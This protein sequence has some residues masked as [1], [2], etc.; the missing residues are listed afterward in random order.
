MG[1]YFSQFFPPTPEFT[2]SSL[3][4]LSGKVYIVTGASA[5]VGRQLASLLYSR[6][7]TVYL[8]TRNAA[9]VQDTID[10]I[11]TSHPASSGAL[12][13]LKLDLN[14]LEGIK[15]SVEEFLSKEKRLDVLWNNAGIMIPPKGNVTK[16]GHEQQL[17]T[18][19]IAPFL[20][21]K[22]LTPLLVQT[23]KTSPAGE[24][25]VVWVSSFA[26]ELVAK[27]GVDVGGLDK[28]VESDPGRVYGITKAGNVLHAQEY[29]RRYGKDGVVSIALNPGNL[30]SELQ[31]NVPWYGNFVLSPILYP[32]VNGAY[33]EL[34]AGLSP[35][36]P[37]APEGSWV[38]P[39]G[40]IVPL[41]KDLAEGEIAV[42]F[43]DWCEKQVERYV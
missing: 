43:W 39:W 29:G 28:L 16:Q 36:V 34:F 4:S 33:T 22:L 2:E 21:T 17:G 32:P 9:K 14:D 41:R 27:G 40:R 8:A 11:K 5:G 42:E 23:A 12:H 1:N 13:F 6:N 30:R 18:N 7:G 38:V 26:A 20:F 31:R 19:C 25:R 35:D 37:K 24:V 10:W 3:P 15:P